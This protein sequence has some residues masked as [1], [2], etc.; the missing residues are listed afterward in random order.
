MN[1]VLMDAADE[2]GLKK[3]DDF[4][5]DEH[6]GYGRSQFTIVNGTRCS[7]AKAFLNPIRHRTNLHIIKHAFATSLSFGDNTTIR[8]VNF[9]LRNK[10][11][12]RTIARKEVIISTGAVN[13]PKLLLLS[14]IGRRSVLDPV[15]IVQRADLGTGEN[16]QDHVT[17]SL[18]F[19]F[20]RSSREVVNLTL[21]KILN[22]FI[23][24]LKNRQQPLT[25]HFVSSVLAFA[26]TVDIE[27]PF[28]D[29]QWEYNLFKKGGV[30]SILLIRDMGYNEQIVQSVHKA[31][32]E[33][34]VVMLRINVLNPESRGRIVLA[35][36]DPY[37]DPVINAGYLTNYEDLKTLIRAIR[38]NEQMLSTESFRRN[39][40]E[41]HR[42]DIPA[43]KFILFDSDE[44]WECYI[45]HMTT[46][47]YHPAGT[48]KMGPD[49][50]PGAVVDSRLKVKQ[51]KNLRVIDASIM[52]FV[53]SGNLNAPTIM[54]GEKGAD[55]IKQDYGL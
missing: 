52:P 27:D 41:L 34:D 38:I 42:L 3:L 13:T 15:R 11:S 18:F 4:N 54:I 53:V 39:E 36:N 25:N 30:S 1:R 21:E 31:E 24:T 23:F 29:V 7:P 9:A 49:S 50:D 51:I 43:C 8:G 40:A 16:L 12:M 45:R 48:A 22:L 26:N 5:R 32:L 19:K 35:S 47:L 28:P 17:V 46:T 10:F 44:Y 37:V 2:I 33:A 14:G 20:N 55:I 6:I